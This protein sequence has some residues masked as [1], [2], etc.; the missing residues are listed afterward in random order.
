MGSAGQLKL[1]RLA[2][3]GKLVEGNGAISCI[4][5]E[6]SLSQLYNFPVFPLKSFE[7]QLAAAAIEVP[8]VGFAP[9]GQKTTC[10]LLWL[11]LSDDSAA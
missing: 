4:N 3:L 2:Q 1:W 6:R 9:C 11:G 10:R 5:H 8:K 7:F